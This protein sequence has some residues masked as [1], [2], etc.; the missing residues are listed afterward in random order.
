MTVAATT[1]DKK[2]CEGLTEEQWA[3]VSPLIPTPPGRLDGR[4]RPWR[5]SREV[6]DGILWKL[7]T[8]ARWHD[9]PECFPPHQ[10]CHRRFQLW[11]KEDV[12]SC[13]LKAIAEDL[14]QRGGLDLTD[15][16]VEGSSVFARQDGS[17]KMISHSQLRSSWQWQTALIFLSPATRKLLRRLRSPLAAKL[18]AVSWT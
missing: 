4:G 17:W 12:L 14:R 10:T 2:S 11:V 7:R 5:C 13:V 1:F 16:C 3:L 15:C 6:L 18:S 8:N 9:L